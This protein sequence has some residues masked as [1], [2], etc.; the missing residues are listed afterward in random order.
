M[1]TVRMLPAQPATLIGRDADAARIR[2]ALAAD[3]V[4]LLTLTGPGGVGK[5]C[6]AVTV[7]ASIA[8]AY[9]HG[10][11]F[12]DLAPLSDPALVISAIGRAL[13]I[14]ETA[15][16]PLLM[17]VTRELQSR[18][19]LLLLDNFEHLL[20]AAST[21]SELI[22]TCPLLQ[23]LV[24]SRVALRLREEREVKVPL[25]A[26]PNDDHRHDPVSLIGVPAVAL[27]VERARTARS[28]FSV[29][30][31]NTATVA[32]VAARLEG[33]PLAIELAAARIKLMSAETL[34]QL[35][36]RPLDLLA[37]GA[38][39]TPSRQQ[40]VRATIAWSYDLLD[41]GSRA[42]LRRL[43]VFAGGCTLEAAA[44]VA[45]E[46]GEQIGDVLDRM[47]PLVDAQLLRTEEQPDG[48]LRFRMLETV[49][50]FA[51]ERLE[52]DGEAESTQRRHAEFFLALAEQAEPPIK[53]GERDVWLRQLDA[54]L[55]NIRAAL[56][57]CRSNPAAVEIG[58]RLAA[59][60]DMYWHYRDHWREA[61]G[62]L[63]SLLA[64]DVAT[65]QPA[66]RAAALCEA[67]RLDVFLRNEDA[68]VPLDECVPMARALGETRTLAYA[69]TWLSRLARDK[70]DNARGRAFA[71]EAVALFRT[72]ADRWG[73]ALALWYEATAPARLNDDAALPLTE[74]SLRLFR[75]LHDRWG[76]ALGYELLANFQ[77]RRGN[78][79]A[80]RQAA[81]NALELRRAEGVKYAIASSLGTLA[82]ILERDG[83]YR[84]AATAYDES[85]ALRR[86]L[87]LMHELATGLRRRGYVTHRLNQEKQALLHLQESLRINASHGYEPGM[88][89]TIAGIAAVTMA[90][91]R[92]EL[93]A[94]LAAAAQSVIDRAGWGNHAGE[95]AAYERNIAAA[96][97]DEG[98]MTRASAEV[99]GGPLTL[100]EATERALQIE[101]P[102]AAVTSFG[103][104]AHLPDG[105]TRRESEV[106]RLVA[107]GMSNREIAEALVVS[108]RTVEKH[109]ARLY[110]KI[111][112]R[113][114][115][116]ATTYAVR[117]GLLSLDASAAP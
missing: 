42:T 53:S 85:I 38:R 13:D 96:R 24:T 58:L 72:T 16:E 7:T 8:G 5:T 34:L 19:L 80:A 41:G 49:R 40:S 25:L 37:G 67:G 27:F 31:A 71:A 30:D 32:A 28:G 109:I 12:V 63:G 91:G 54:D 1:D 110:A 116:D 93:A 78:T 76:M 107:A 82:N 59:T 10:V 86:E 75:E 52:A 69:L 9:Q 33:L 50:E 94:Q 36:G 11:C 62:W 47:E 61:R 20:D 99:D 26:I 98:G 97:A 102:V 14:Q 70:G 64:I 56:A 103:R 23:I 74:E 45:G 87:G 112:A 22:A 48:S 108:V 43:A 44:V 57:W 73:L 55:D 100:Q 2:T 88:A 29:T 6:L 113:G 46:E 77:A 39:D 66:V 117:H 79:A 92:P 65:I 17:T 114:R 18:R 115:A 104:H 51:L 35:F 4:R 89:L 68:H 60:L 105:I 111:N 106:L 95:R 84:R 101:P 3:G 21:V 90:I 83:N 15:T 81:E